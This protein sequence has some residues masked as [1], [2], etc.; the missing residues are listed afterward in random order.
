MRRLWISCFPVVAVAALF[1]TL[2]PA[3]DRVS[4]S[5]PVIRT[6]VEGVS[7]SARFQ[8]LSPERRYRIG[9]GVKGQFPQ[10]EIELSRE[11][12][13]LPTNPTDFVQ[14]HTGNWWGVEQLS[15]R[16]YLIEG[17][18]IGGP[19]EE[20][21]L[22]VSIPRAEA[23]KLDHIYIFISRDYGSDTWYLEDGID[24]DKSYW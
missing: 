13:P 5:S 18:K 7:I 6:T 12:S 14:Q 11:D 9:V 19:S 21:L 10:A 4:M 23:D 15:A 1:Q 24:L 3:Q 2:L 22:R 17:S 8:G 16:G 20:L